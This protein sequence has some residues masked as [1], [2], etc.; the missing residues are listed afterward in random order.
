[1]IDFNQFF[2]GHYLFNGATFWKNTIGKVKTLFF[3]FRK[4]TGLYLSIYLITTDLSVE[5]ITLFLTD[6]PR[7]FT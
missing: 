2:K 6:K 5:K 3:P 1:M 4:K 7:Y